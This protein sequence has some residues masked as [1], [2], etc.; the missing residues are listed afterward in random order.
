MQG[1]RQYLP[2][3][4]IHKQYQH[5]VS[6]YP[7]DCPQMHQHTSGWKT[8]N[9][10]RH[11]SHMHMSHMHMSH[12]GTSVP[13]HCNLFTRFLNVLVGKDVIDSH[14]KTEKQTI[15]H[16]PIISHAPTHPYVGAR[17]KMWCRISGTRSL[18]MVIA[19]SKTMVIPNYSHMH[20]MCMS[21]TCRLH[22]HV[23]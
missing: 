10:G 6:L 13:C 20:V 16:A 12:A 1:R 14:S 22:V 19:I 17:R 2:Q 15:S 23:T 9:T 18:S 21:H 3:R 5:Q 7:G 11:M 8:W 4:D